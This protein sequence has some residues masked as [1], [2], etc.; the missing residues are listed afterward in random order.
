[1]RTVSDRELRQCDFSGQHRLALFREEA[2]HIY[3]NIGG[4]VKFDTHRWC[5]TLVFVL[6][7]IVYGLTMADSVSFWDCGEFTA[8]ANEMGVPHP[9]GSPLFLLV[10]RVF[11][12]LPISHDIAVRVTWMSVLAS[13]FAILFAY[14]IIVR[15]IRMIRGRGKDGAG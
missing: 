6:A 8:C 4:M 9:P 15:L 1:M 7:L 11:S 13:A 5:A 3:S 2:I 10:G 14:L 12:L